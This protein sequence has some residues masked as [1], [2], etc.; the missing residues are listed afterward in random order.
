VSEES[1][2]KS[3]IIFK[4]IPEHMQLRHCAVTPKKKLQQKG[5]A[6]SLLLLLPISRVPAPMTF[7]PLYHGDQS[8]T[9]GI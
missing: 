3:K 5:E 6:N 7:L 2:L 9:S 8:V 4:Q 1:N